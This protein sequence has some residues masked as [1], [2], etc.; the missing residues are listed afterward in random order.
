[1]RLIENK[2]LIIQSVFIF[3]A[4]QTEESYAYLDPGTGSYLI[5]VVIGVILG[6]LYAL[7]IFWSKIKYFFKNLLKK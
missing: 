3:L 6:G 5:Q 4:L 1:M 7:K 2:L